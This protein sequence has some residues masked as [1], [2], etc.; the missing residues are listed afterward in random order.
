MNTTSPAGN[1]ASVTSVAHRR[2]AMTDLPEPGGGAT[3]DDLK[4][5]CVMID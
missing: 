4:N 2:A 5:V 1:R 3:E